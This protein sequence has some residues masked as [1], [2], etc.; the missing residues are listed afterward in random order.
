MHI[1]LEQTSAPNNLHSTICIIG[2]G[3]AGLVLA[4]RLAHQGIDVCLLEAGGLKPEERSQALYRAHIAPGA[5]EHHGVN[6]GRFR[7]FGGTS[8]RWGGQLLPFTPDIFS[9]GP[10]L[11]NLA[12]PI[13]ERELTPY[14]DEIQQLLGVDSL[15]YTSELS[16][17]LGAPPLPPSENIRVR[18]SKWIP[19]QRRNLGQTLGVEALSHPKITVITHA[20]TASLEV[21][22]T[23]PS[24]I[25]R[26]RVL[27]YSG[28]ELSFT[29]DRFI[30]ACGTIES[31]RLLLCS[32]SVPNPYDL[33]GRYFHD[34]VVCH[35]AQFRSPTRERVARFIGPFFV[36]GTMHT[37]KLE[38]SDQ[39]RERERLLSVMSHVAVVEPEDSGPAA[40]RNLMWSLQQ[41]RLREAL[42]RN[43]VPMMRG[44]GEVAHLAWSLKFRRRRPISKRAILYLNIDVEQNPDPN[45]RI[46]LHPTERDALG[47]PI[48]VVDWRIGEAEKR[49][50][51]AYARIIR[52]Y[53]TAN[54]LDPVDWAPEWAEGNTPPLVDT[55]HAMGGLRMGDDPATSVVD[56]NLRLHQLE[57]LY[58]ASCAV[59]P[60]GSSSNP[61]FTMV[62]LAMRLADRIA[63]ELRTQ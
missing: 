10:G 44:L 36:D 4:K 47:L 17:A 50:V 32:P 18:F 11:P 48:T 35:A 19:F 8:T 46:T 13:P 42:T 7:T 54:G 2:A 56:R 37:C 14:Y 33:I 41:G 15:P 12:W 5:Q 30:V 9:P 55:I 39:L 58:V 45:N 29:A 62:A 40:I 23:A 57:N 52:E 3:I 28:R 20:N 16:Q 31:S 34:H 38:A 53:L 21:D 59:F 51:L 49:T 22:P 25:V 26:A 1:D 24:R 6:T 27:T 43:L 61:T 63:S 60:A